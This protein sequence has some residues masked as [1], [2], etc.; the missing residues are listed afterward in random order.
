MYAGEYPAA[1]PRAQDG[2]RTNFARIVSDSEEEA[3]S[4]HD[5]DIGNSEAAALAALGFSK[6]LLASLAKKARQNG[7]S[8][9]A[10]LLNSG[11]VGENAYYGAVARFLRLPFIDVIDPQSLPDTP[12]IDTQLLH[13]NQVRITYRY[14]APQ[15]AIVPEAMRLAD[16]AA[17]LAAM[18]MLRRNLVV[19]TPSAIRQAVW[20]AGAGRR[21]RHAVTDLFDRFPQF[22]ARIVLAGRQGFYAGLGFAVLLSALV[23]IPIETLGILHV[24]L[25][26]IYLASLLL[27][28]A[29]LTA[30]HFTERSYAYIHDPEEPLPR[31]TIMVALYREADV[32]RQLVGSLRRI[33]WP[34]PLLDIKL[35]CE[36]DDHATIAALRALHLDPHFEI[37]EVPPSGPRTK[38]KALTYALSAARGEFL[39]IYDA[40]DR[41]HPQQLREAYRHF[42]NSPDRVAC[43]QAPLI[44]T[45]A[46]ESWISA[47]FSLEYAG[48]FRGLLPML[49]RWGMPLPLGGTSNHFRT[50][51]LRTAG[52]WDPFNVTEDADLGMRLYRLGYRAETLMRQ[53]LEDAPTA[54]RVWMGQRSRWFK[55]WLQTWLVLMRAPRRLMRE[56]GAGAFCI[57]QLMIGG[58]LMSSLLHPLI[59]VFVAMGAYAMTEAP[60]EDI[61]T[62]MLSLFIIDLVNILGSY[63]IFLALGMGSMISHEKR[64][65]GRRWAG[66]PLYWL[67]TSAAAWLAVVELHSKPFFWNKTSHVPTGR[68]PGV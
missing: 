29:A 47:L 8:L 55:G 22:S 53:T 26:L 28:L 14:R 18:P 67:M 21:V 61:P 23:V 43:L 40:E 45:N 27:R 44:I 5:P 19:T 42:R 9:E 37:V 15:V 36:A 56:M 17:T 65:I 60:T 62:G 35:V 51:A 32:A 39:A 11:E 52:G 4:S 68:K 16:L 20:K 10:E 54:M 24:T 58:M 31:Y 59:L 34:R 48:L 12:F 2:A 41:P 57:F 66:L 1:S 46:Q 38:P 6:P 3:S 50:A 63:A 64:M 7:T 30:Q 25:S 13:P 49:A 33:D